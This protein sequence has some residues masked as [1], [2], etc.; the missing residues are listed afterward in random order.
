MKTTT[1]LVLTGLA[2]AGILAA[3]QP[4][5]AAAGVPFKLDLTTT[6]T[7]FLDPPPLPVVMEIN[8]AGTGTHVGLCTSESTVTWVER[9]GG[10][11]FSGPLTITAANGDELF[12][13]TFG[14]SF[15]D[16]GD[17]DYVITGGTGRFE[18]ATGS[19]SF[20]VVV[21]ADGSQTATLDGTISY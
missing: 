6:S 16:G 9:S 19:G 3:A 5:A 21:N 15:P 1:S 8:A 2:L 18:D 4:T 13:D 14:W 11:W 17:G 7:K 10:V 20:D 12:L